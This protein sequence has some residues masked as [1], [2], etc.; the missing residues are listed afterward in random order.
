MFRNKIGRNKKNSR[1]KKGD[2]SYEICVPV[3]KV[4]PPD[5]REPLLELNTIQQCPPN[6][7][8]PVVQEHGDGVPTQVVWETASAVSY[9]H[10]DVYKRQGQRGISRAS[11]HHLLNQGSQNQI[12]HFSKINFSFLF[13]KSL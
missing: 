8:C 13:L 11:P 3:N 4:Y 2:F 10:L 6:V 12:I 9:T 5:V 1:C 7:T